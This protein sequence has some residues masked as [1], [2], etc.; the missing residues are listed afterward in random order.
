ML[1]YVKYIYKTKYILY[2]HKINVHL[3]AQ[4]QRKKEEKMNRFDFIVVGG[5]LAGLYAA[6]EL[7][8][9]G[10]VALI[11]E[12]S[13]EDSNSYH[14]QG[15]M[16][17]VTDPADSIT[18]HF[19]DTMEAGRGLCDPEAV[20]TLTREAPRR[21]DNLI[22]EGM[23]FDTDPG[24]KPSLGLEGGHH[25][26]RILHAGGDATGRLVTTFM[27]GR[28]RKSE[29]ITI[30]SNHHLA[31]MV[32]HDGRC[33]GVWCYHK[34]TGMMELF[35]A[36]S[37]I[38]ATGGAAALYSPTTNPPTALGDGIALALE[39]GATVRDM[40]FVQFHPTAL[41]LPSRPAF[42]ISEAVRGEGA[43]LLDKEGRRFMDGKHPLAELAPRDVVARMIYHTMQQES[44][45]HVMLSLAHLDKEHIRHRFPT[46]SDY[47]RSEGVDFTESIPV[48]PAAHYTVGGIRT[49]LNGQT[50]IDGLYAVGET[51]S[52]GVMGANRLASNSLVECL[53]F[54][55]RIADHVECNLRQPSVEESLRLS[56][57][58][59]APPVA[60]AA[61]EARWMADKG[62]LFM[63]QLGKTMTHNVG[64]V[65]TEESL[66][67]ALDDIGKAL[68]VLE[69]DSKTF[70]AAREV[71][72]R[73]R[74]GWLTARSA[75][76]REES[77]GG[78]WRDD[79]RQTLPAEEAFHTLIK[80]ND[81]SHEKAVSPAQ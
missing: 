57:T 14:A 47:C 3:Q 30:L 53:V 72:R 46:I 24:G 27:I 41:C 52:T 32:I 12:M 13:L 8:K 18:D 9:K 17:A 77:R 73:H 33:H 60:D 35:L 62:S 69:A 45:D 49:D 7:S 6:H 43:H 58:H 37:T 59:D 19:E 31:S 51:A 36:S 76:M 21:I 75:R 16:A 23:M 80:H 22:E 70:F 66:D 34:T 39:A 67:R 61:S 2:F 74:V 40:E 20:R 5:G 81:I 1:S 42:L 10:R 44:Q 11:A 68:Q 71:Y 50:D 65:R 26:H 38:L 4:R 64:I 48:S 25:H 15:G 78:H 63:A 29:R 55:K 79:H 54:G 56:L 28:V